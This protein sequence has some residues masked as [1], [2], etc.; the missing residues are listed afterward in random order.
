[1]INNKKAEINYP[2][3]WTYTIIGTD[4]QTMKQAVDSVIQPESYSF[5]ESNRSNKGKYVSYNVELVV[6]NEHERDRYFRSLG[7]H[8]AI[9]M[10]L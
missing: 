10:V 3:K 7:E 1:M 8:K 9:K 4:P 5:K 6:F 2:A